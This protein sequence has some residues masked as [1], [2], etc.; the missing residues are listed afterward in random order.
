MTPKE[1]DEFEQSAERIVR[2]H[3]QFHGRDHVDL[4]EA[5]ASALRQTAEKAR[6]EER[7]RAINYL[8]KICWE[9]KD[10]EAFDAW[11]RASPASGRESEK[12][13]A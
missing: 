6:K 2:F 13:E 4:V 11:G 3:T 9:D 8:K 1:P 12:E 10:I 5:I 7:E